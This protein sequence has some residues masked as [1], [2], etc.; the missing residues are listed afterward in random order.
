M[1]Y[2]QLHKRLEVELDHARGGARS[3]PG[4][5][6]SE[7]SGAKVHVQLIR[8]SPRVELRRYFAVI[9]PFKKR[10]SPETRS[11]HYTFI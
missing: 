10:L 1:Y 4:C 3:V 7:R 6:P 11:A 8:L 5:L 9:L 2:I